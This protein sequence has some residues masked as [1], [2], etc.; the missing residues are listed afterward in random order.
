[1]AKKRNNKS[2]ISKEKYVRPKIEKVAVSSS[3]KLSLCGAGI[4]TCNPSSGGPVEPQY[5]FDLGRF[6][7]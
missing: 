4:E 5:I 3:Y 6:N 2:R 1:M 7:K